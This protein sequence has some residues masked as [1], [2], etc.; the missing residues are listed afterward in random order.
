MVDETP[1]GIRK[2]MLLLSVMLGMMFGVGLFVL[3]TAIAKN[4][5]SLI[6]VGLPM[7]I[8]AIPMAANLK[9]LRQT[10]KRQPPTSPS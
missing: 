7:F 3:V 4:R 5:P 6:A 1:A 9:R 8:I 10:A 2:R